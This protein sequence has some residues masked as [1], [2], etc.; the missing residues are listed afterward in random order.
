M[1]MYIEDSSTEKKGEWIERVGVE[2]NPKATTWDVIRDAGKLPLVLVDNG[3]FYA[4]AV[5]Y[6]ESEFN[7]FMR[8]TDKRLK[9]WYFLDERAVKARMDI[10]DWDHYMSQENEG[11]NS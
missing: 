9:R 2:F 3:M 10:E 7:A 6:N 1:G 5:A 4:L 8:D 11:A